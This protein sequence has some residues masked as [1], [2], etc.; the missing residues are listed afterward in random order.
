MPRKFA[1]VPLLLG[2]SAFERFGTITLDNDRN[3][4]V[5]KQ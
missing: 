5:I 2:Q 3:L 1:S 4:I